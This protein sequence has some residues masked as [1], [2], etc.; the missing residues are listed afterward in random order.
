MNHKKYNI[1]YADPPWQYGSKKYQDGDRPFDKLENQYPTMTIEEI[2]K[3]LVRDI[4]EEDAACFLWVTDSHLKEGIE[5]LESWGFR[6]KTISFVWIKKYASGQNCIN[7]APW[8]LKSHEICL[9]GIKGKMTKYKKQNNIY[10]LVEAV[11]STHSTKP[12]AVRKR[13]ELLFGD[14]PKIELFARTNAVGWDVWGNEVLKS[15]SL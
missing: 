7:F 1:I 3:L 10:S 12:E 11:R 5:V 6:Y 2:K 14:M 13:I 8:T 15:I 4:I 9:L